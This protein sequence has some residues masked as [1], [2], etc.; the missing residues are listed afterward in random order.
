MHFSIPETET[1]AGD[2]GA[3][4]Y[5]VSGAEGA[6]LSRRTEPPRGAEWVARLLGPGAVRP[7]WGRADPQPRRGGSGSALGPRPGEA[8]RSRPAA[9]PGRRPVPRPSR[10]WAP[11]PPRLRIGLGRSLEQPRGCPDLALPGR[12]GRGLA[13][14][15]GPVRSHPQ[16]RL[17][18]ARPSV[19]LSRLPVLVPAP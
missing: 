3:A 10:D 16:L 15:R 18:L 17:I 19:R 12:R 13:A 14:R 1:R 4:A 5:V 8:G 6:E 2:G 7:R 11:P 9:V